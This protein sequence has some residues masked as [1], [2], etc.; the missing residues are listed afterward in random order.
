MD[1]FVLFWREENTLSNYTSTKLMKVK[2]DVQRYCLA[3][4]FFTSKFVVFLNGKNR[5]IK[6]VSLGPSGDTKFCYIPLLDQYFI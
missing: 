3:T 4:T 2:I 6:K 1:F 5:I